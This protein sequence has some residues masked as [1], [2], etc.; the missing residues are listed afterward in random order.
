MEQKTKPT[1]DEIYSTQASYIK[2]FTEM[3]YFMA[4][5]F[6][7]SWYHKEIT[8]ETIEETIKELY[9]AD[10]SETGR[11]IVEYDKDFLGLELAIRI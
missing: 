8:L 2:Y 9:E 1:W 10:S 4:H 6:G 7:W 3:F 11:I 5:H